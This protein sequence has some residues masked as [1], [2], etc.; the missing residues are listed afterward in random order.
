MFEIDSKFRKT[1]IGHLR[2]D[3]AWPAGQ[4]DMNETVQTMGRP[5]AT[6]ADGKMDSSRERGGLRLDRLRL[7]VALDT[8]LVEGSV[9]RAAERMGI[10]T[11]AMSR[12]LKQIREL[13][14]DP[15]LVRTARGMVPTP[16]AETLRLRLRAVASEADD[17][18]EPARMQRNAGDD[19]LPVPA[20]RIN[21]APPLAMRPHFHIEGAPLPEDLARR[22]AQIGALDHPQRRLAK[23]IAISG[24]GAG[25]T[26]PLTMEEA[27][28]AFAIILDGAANPIQIGALLVVMNYR[29]TTAAE[30]AGFVRASWRHI[31]RKS[32][33]PGVI[34]LDWPAYISPR[35]LAAPW[36]L[37]AAR[38]VA[39]AGY[40]VLIHGQ[41]G[42]TPAGDRLEAASRALGIPVSTSS[43]SAVS[44]IR[45]AGIAYLPLAGI[46]QQIK[47][48]IAL[49]GLFEMRSP[50][51][52]LVHLLNPL[53]A[54]A[55]L[56][57]VGRPTYRELHRDAAA[58]LGFRNIAVLGNTRDVAEFTPY[59]HTTIYRLAG[60]EAVDLVVPSLHQP[61]TEPAPGLSSAEYWRVVW[62]GQARDERARQIVI[63]SAAVA[64][65]TL[66]G[67][68]SA[69]WPA[70]RNQATELWNA[71]LHQGSNM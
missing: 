50:M 43:A 64:L 66:A 21:A 23:F 52:L 58:M 67:S 35:S 62:Q 4:C 41:Q 54:P 7:L 34:D 48:L 44:A 9:G 5:D 46:S 8:L 17:L 56:L 59:R 1:Q 22:L 65:M 71:R 32:I 33:P 55:S 13:Y 14:S 61:R 38:L 10:G 12:L 69:D 40:K 36:F 29:G 6:D 3:A 15:I 28:D 31:G 53:G 20:S 57:G 68:P 70:F 25:R 26:R 27:E 18:L 30:L 2:R 42:G 19:A 51:N 39:Q 47:Q 60:G 16:F 63:D 49:Y 37:Q 24:A 11:P 45:E